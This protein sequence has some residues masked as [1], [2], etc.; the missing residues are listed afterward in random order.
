[1]KI[2]AETMKRIFADMTAIW[3]AV[4]KAKQD[5]M[6]EALTS[7]NI[8][9]T[10]LG[11]QLYHLA[12]ADRNYDDSHPRYQTR[13]RI[14]PL[15]PFPMYPDGAND[16]HMTTMFKR[17]ELPPVTV[18]TPQAV[19][20]DE[21]EEEETRERITCDQ[22]ELLAINGVFDPK[23]ADVSTCGEY[24]AYSDIADARA[25][26]RDLAKRD[27]AGEHLQPTKDSERCEFCGTYRTWC[28]GTPTE[29]VK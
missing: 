3:N 8:T 16:D 7:G 23:T 17:F 22:C 27:R 4:P 25:E 11:W 10:N 20:Q 12:F 5:E 28:S 21:E 15:A 18:D 1:M 6:R 29:A 9:I 19:P 24:G 14:L 26:A 2:Q 13:E